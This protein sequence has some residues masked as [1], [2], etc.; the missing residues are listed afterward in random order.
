MHSI[1]KIGISVITTSKLSTLSTL[2]MNSKTN[3]SLFFNITV[4]WAS[5]GKNLKGNQKNFKEI[6]QKSMT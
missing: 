3:Y 6:V 1:Q 4:H 2:Y 5:H